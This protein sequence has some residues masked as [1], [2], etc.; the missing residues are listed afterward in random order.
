M[1]ILNVSD[2]GKIY[3]KGHLEIEVLKNVS[4]SVEP[5]EFVSI[6]GPSGSGKTTLLYVLSG[7]ETYDKGSVMLFSK[8]LSSYTNKEKA[9]LRSMNIGFVFQ[10]YHLI[11]NLNIYEN[12]KLAS[13]IGK[14]VSHQKII[15][16]LEMVGMKDEIKSYPSQLSGGQ[17]QRVAIARALINDPKILFADEPIGNLDYQS[18]LKIMAL[19]KELNQTY[20]KTIFMVTHNIDTT[21]YGSR[22]LHM[23]SGR[24][25]KDE[26]VIQ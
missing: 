23:L 14:D 26:K 20:H 16:T 18:G 13:V 8:E 10:F 11:P 7:L 6:I 15:D 2:I 19:F 9:T 25:I 12:V 5:G 21:S 3:H 4:L 22:T 24:I 1:A 17:Q